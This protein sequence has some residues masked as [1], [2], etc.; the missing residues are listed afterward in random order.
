MLTREDD[1]LMIPVIGAGFRGVEE[2]IVSSIVVRDDT[3][4]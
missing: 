2:Q 1:A 3:L 4:S